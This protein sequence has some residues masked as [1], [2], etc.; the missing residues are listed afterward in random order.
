MKVLLALIGIAL[1]A[2][3]VYCTLH[4]HKYIG[5]GHYFTNPWMLKS[6]ACILGCF[7]VR[8]A[9]GMVKSTP[10]VCYRDRSKDDK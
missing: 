10:G 5:T 2:Y 3:G 4:M 1:C 6:T 7:I 8:I 9:M